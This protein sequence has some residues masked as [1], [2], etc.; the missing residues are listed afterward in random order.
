MFTHFKGALTEQFAAQEMGAYGL[1]LNYWSPDDAKAE[2]EFV[3]QIG[4]SIYPVEAK[5]E[6]N[7]KAKSLMSYIKRYSPTRAFRLSMS[8]RN[9][10]EV[11][12]DYPLYA[13]REML[14]EASL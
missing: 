12:E 7:L 6:K 9:S 10:S 4:A 11:I 14:N 5:A 8:K 1:R 2:I 3:V 13:I